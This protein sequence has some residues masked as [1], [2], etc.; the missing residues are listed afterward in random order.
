MAILLFAYLRLRRLANLARY[1]FTLSFFRVLN[2]T[3][4]KS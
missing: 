4:R 3:I 2:K 1:F